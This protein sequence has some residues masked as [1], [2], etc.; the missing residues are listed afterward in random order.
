MAEQQTA[1]V[2]QET[3]VGAVA[4]LPRDLAII[5]MDNDSMMALAAAH[6]RDYGKVLQSVASQMA[7]YPTFAEDAVFTKPAGKD[8]NGKM[9][10]VHNLSIRAAEAL[11]EAYRYCKVRADVTILDQDTVRVEASFTDFQTGRVWQDAGIVSKVYTTYKGGTSR[12]SDD[13]F[14]NVVVKAEK[15]KHI[16]ECIIRSVPPGLRSE[17]IAR[18]D[19]QL[20][21]FL[22]ATTQDRIVSQFRAKGVTTEMLESLMGKS[23]GAFRTKDRTLLAGIW[24][25]LEDGETTVAEAFGENGGKKTDAEIEAGLRKKPEPPPAPAN[26]TMTEGA[27]P[28]TQPEGAM[29]VQAPLPPEPP[30]AAESPVQ[31]DLASPTASEGPI[32]KTSDLYGA[33]IKAYNAL[34]TMWQAQIRKECGI[35]TITIVATWD[36]TAANNVLDAIEAKL[37]EAAT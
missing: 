21:E 10:Y 34:G 13:R 20:G 30:P 2:Q 9:K 22:D 6:E 16:R 23:L 7:A 18:V 19:A 5:K 12:Y 17:L 4:Q 27:P 3:D 37:A 35:K 24:R 15:S 33:I 25:A 11:A 32:G 14:Y 1:I 26:E 31:A 36:Q 28:T 29:A 8:K